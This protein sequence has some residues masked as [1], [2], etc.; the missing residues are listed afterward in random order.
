MKQRGVFFPSLPTAC[1]IPPPTSGGGGI[2]PEPTPVLTDGRAT[3]LL[4]RWKRR[5]LSWQHLVRWNFYPAEREQL[6]PQVF[7]GR[8]E[9]IDG[10]VEDEEAVL[11]TRCSNRSIRW[12]KA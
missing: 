7:E 9:V 1:V 8:A 11:L 5:L 10:V 6:L 3:M 2:S 12:L 4:R